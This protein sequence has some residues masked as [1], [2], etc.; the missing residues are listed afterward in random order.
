MD[1]STV[2]R[3]LN[4]LKKHKSGILRVKKNNGHS[5]HYFLNPKVIAELPLADPKSHEVTQD[6]VTL[7][8]K[9]HAAMTK[10]PEFEYKEI[11]G[12]EWPRAFQNILDRGSSTT[13]IIKVASH[14]LK[15]QWKADM[16]QAGAAALDS[17]FDVIHADYIEISKAVTK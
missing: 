8:E 13:T 5:S 12:T 7:A 15:H 16:L 17:L 10:L 6:A 4:T 2:Q 3:T 1:V 9:L 11:Y 14:G